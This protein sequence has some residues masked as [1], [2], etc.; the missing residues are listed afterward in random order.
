MHEIFCY[1]IHSQLVTMTWGLLNEELVPAS[2]G[3]W[4]NSH[5]LPICSGQFSCGKIMT[6][7]VAVQWFRWSFLIFISPSLLI[8]LLPSTM[9]RALVSTV[10]NSWNSINV[11]TRDLPP[12]E[13]TLPSWGA[14]NGNTGPDGKGMLASEPDHPWGPFLCV[15]FI[16]STF[17]LSEYQKWPNKVR[18]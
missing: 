9:E 5:V 13:S 17:F 14:A 16:C 3:H 12:S 8:C 10:A 7:V 4:F 15:S 6:L 18:Y 1:H 2:W 11:I